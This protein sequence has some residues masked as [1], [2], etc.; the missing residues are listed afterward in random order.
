MI[1]FLGIDQDGDEVEEA[2][3]SGGGG[4]DEVAEDDDDDESIVEEDEDGDDTKLLEE[5]E[6][7]RRELLLKATDDTKDQTHAIAATN[8]PVATSVTDKSMR[9]EYLLAQS[10]VFAHFLAG[11]II[12]YFIY[13]HLHKYQNGIIVALY[14]IHILF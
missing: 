3:L 10:E 2:C 13:I 12:S 1:F 5:A 7:E 11:T 9:L 4:G 8:N 6:K 14:F